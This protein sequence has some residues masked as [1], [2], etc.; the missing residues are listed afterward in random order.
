MYILQ[1]SAWKQRFHKKIRITKKNCK[2]AKNQK[3]S[4]Y[5][6][7]VPDGAAEAG[8]APGLHGA[9][10]DAAGAH[11]RRH[12]RVPR[13]PGRGPRPQPRHQPDRARGG[14]R[15]RGQAQ[16]PRGRQPAPLGHPQA[17]ASNEPYIREKF[18]ITEKAPKT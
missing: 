7:S 18:T 16:Q 5:L 17:R 1:C 10:G 12:G 3:L 13:P 9:P 4:N 11:Q 8:A 2:S 14:A 15:H 6:C